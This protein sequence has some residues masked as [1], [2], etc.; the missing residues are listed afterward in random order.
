M[1]TKYQL[2]GGCYMDIF[3]PVFWSSLMSI[4]IIDLVLAGDNAIVIGMAA[5]NLPKELQMKAIAWGTAG[6]IIIRIVAT[7][8]VVWL[9]KIPGLLLI[10][11]V[12]LIWIA[13]KLLVQKKNVAKV[14][15]QTSVMS[16]IG[17]IVVAD[18]I[19]G[20]DNIIA[21]AGA[22]SGNIW[23]V[24]FGLLLSV[25]IIV[26]GS[27]LI[28]KW[29]ERY[30]VILYVGAGVLALTAGKMISSE[31]S[32]ST[33]FA[34]NPFMRWLMIGAIITFVIIY[35]LLKRQHYFTRA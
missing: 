27:R 7:A 31:A 2:V 25:P 13:T 35:G 20:L 24:I 33:Y 5:R 15:A 30:P 8:L 28:I 6:A 17:T 32:F 22:A 1:D 4:I 34:A 11:G 21:V 12:L 19:M 18:A 16:A 26:W 9:L 3:S 10:G 14:T 23:L 29:I